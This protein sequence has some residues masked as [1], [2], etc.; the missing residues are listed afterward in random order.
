MDGAVCGKH[1]ENAKRHVRFCIEIYNHQRKEGRFFLH[2]HPWLAS[3]WALP[4]M[5]ELESHGDVEKVR[6][7]MCQFGMV[8]QSDWWCWVHA[9]PRIE[10]DGIP[11][12]L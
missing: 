11:Y 9:R 12:E 5:E 7:D 3:S 1:I 4:E 6:T 8:S 10:A 2:E